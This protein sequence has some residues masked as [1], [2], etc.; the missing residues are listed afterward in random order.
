MPLKR[1]SNGIS[2][3]AMAEGCLFAWGCGWD[4]R[5]G[6][7]DAETRTR[8]SL[9]PADGP[10]VVAA[11]CGWAHT[12]AVTASGAVL[13]WGL[14]DSGQLG[15]GDLTDEA[16]E[17]GAPV[18]VKEL[19]GHVITAVACG[20]GH[21]LALAD[22]GVAW[23]WGKGEHGQLG[24][25]DVSFAAS[26]QRIEGFDSPVSSFSCNRYH[27]IAVTTG[28]G[29]VFAWGRGEYGQLGLGKRDGVRS[30]AHVHGLDG[31][32]TTATCCGWGHSVALVADGSVYS[33]GFGG[34]GQLGHGDMTRHTVPHR[35]EA[36]SGVTHIACGYYH[37]LAATSEAVFS[38]G[39]G[40]RGQLGHGDVNGSSPPLQ[41]C[42]S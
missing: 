12:A 25:G 20:F 9:V 39:R 22:S 19:S 33:W 38:W 5:L 21:T 18:P 6:L 42:M 2:V 8:P 26:P 23:S 3:I 10:G 4:G 14:G 41:L 24:L 35:V 32:G 16:P 40:E 1:E 34:K 17:R 13:C 31:L 30:P 27:C 28:E 7:G 29:A 36:L 37:N 15:V 11:S